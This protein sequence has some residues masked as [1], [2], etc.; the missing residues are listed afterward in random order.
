MGSRRIPLLRGHHRP[1]LMTVPVILQTSRYTFSTLW[2]FCFI[3]WIPIKAHVERISVFSLS[4]FS[5]WPNLTRFFSFFTIY[6]RRLTIPA[7]CWRLGLRQVERCPKRL[8]AQCRTCTCNHDN[9]IKTMTGIEKTDTPLRL[10]GN[11]R[12][13]FQFFILNTLDT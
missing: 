7:K 13:R 8:G 11:T 5:T 9:T 2:R 4:A 12:I 3:D 10:R 1:T 6:G